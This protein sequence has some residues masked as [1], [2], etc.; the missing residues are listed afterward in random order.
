MLK[1][2][3]GDKVKTRCKLNTERKPTLLIKSPKWLLKDAKAEGESEQ[4][5]KHDEHWKC[6]P[7]SVSS[8]Y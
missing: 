2:F 3:Q 5:F 1:V 7:K 6:A 8:V 4:A